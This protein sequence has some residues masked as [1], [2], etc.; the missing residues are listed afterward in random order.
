MKKIFTLLFV[1]V[2]AIGAYA[3]RGQMA[4]GF[5]L[6]AV[7]SLES[8]Y[9]STNFGFG[10]K[11]QYSLTDKIRLEGDVDYI[12]KNKGMSQF[13]L[14]ANAHYMFN[15]APRFNMYPIVGLGYAH[16]NYDGGDIDIDIDGVEFH[17]N[18]SEGR[19]LFN[20]GLGFEYELTRNLIGSFEVKYQYVD[21]WSKLPIA[22]GIAYRF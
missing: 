22:F 1:A 11:F 19:F 21:D 15:I 14:I 3:Q 20:A 6:M 10:G 8:H 4:A 2:M 12:T 17:S 13:D 16:L 5:T 7:P 9:S 18:N